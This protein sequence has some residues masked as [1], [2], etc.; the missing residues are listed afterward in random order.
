MLEKQ[1]EVRIR[2]SS[3]SKFV[4]SHSGDLGASIDN[5]AKSAD[6]L[7][8]RLDRFYSE[9]NG[10]KKA[11]YTSTAPKNLMVNLWAVTPIG[12]LQTEPDNF[13]EKR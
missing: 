10:L 3:T 2:P 5:G 12:K 6:S 9:L 13:S 4:G 1:N 7:K 11:V 8:V